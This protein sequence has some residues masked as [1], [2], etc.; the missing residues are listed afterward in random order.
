MSASIKRNSQVEGIATEALEV[1]EGTNQ[2]VFWMG[3]LMKAITVSLD[4][5]EANTAAGLASLGAHL[6]DEWTHYLEDQTVMFR[7][8]LAEQEAGQ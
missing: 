7:R 3:S 4:H 6:A 2:Q 8:C 1:M 5:Q